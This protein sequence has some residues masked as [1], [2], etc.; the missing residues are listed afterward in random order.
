MAWAAKAAKAEPEA[1]AKP[2]LRAVMAA[3]RA[4]AVMEVLA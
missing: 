3:S 1:Q 4:M 2:V